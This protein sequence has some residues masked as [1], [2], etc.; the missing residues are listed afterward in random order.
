MCGIRQPS[1][2]EPDESVAHA[3]EQVAVDAQGRRGAAAA[4]AAWRRAAELTP[5]G[6]ARARRLLAASEAA[7]EAGASDAARRAADAALAAC[8]TRCCT[9]TSFVSARGIDSQSGGVAEDVSAALQAEADAVAPLDST[10]AAY[11]LA[12]AALAF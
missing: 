8:R 9:P 2:V 4:A 1:L 5:D 7:W 10:R 3:L 6:N 12:D 11:L